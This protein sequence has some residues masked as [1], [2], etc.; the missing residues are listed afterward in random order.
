MCKLTMLSQVGMLHGFTPR[1]P[2][3]APA[4]ATH[5]PI[6]AKSGRTPFVISGEWSYTISSTATKHLI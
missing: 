1:A 5:V 6:M 2:D 4:F 3:L